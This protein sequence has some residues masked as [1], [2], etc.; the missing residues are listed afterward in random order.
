M[1]MNLKMM[2]PLFQLSD[3]VVLPGGLMALFSAVVAVA[4]GFVAYQAYRG[5]Q[6]N[7][8]RPMLFLAVGIVFLTVVPM[9]VNY[10]LS[11]FTTATD[12]AV[13]GAITVAHFTGVVAIL[14]ALTRA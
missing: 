1:E 7:E 5:Y 6:R 14:Y 8:S 13:L 2:F 12:A 3:T 9:G 11:G 10:G 4:G